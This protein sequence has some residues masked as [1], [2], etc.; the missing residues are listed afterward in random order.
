MYLT[1]A[2]QG[3]AG[4]TGHPA[5]QDDHLTGVMYLTGAG[6]GR[7]GQVRPGTPLSRTITSQGVMYLTGAG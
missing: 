7:A 3:R 2:G 1:G 4:Q 5:V 6:Q